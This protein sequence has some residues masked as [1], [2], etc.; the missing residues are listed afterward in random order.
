M[1]FPLVSSRCYA[2]TTSDTREVNRLRIEL[3]EPVM[4]IGK[5]HKLN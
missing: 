2:G 5:V 1:I 3:L 4:N